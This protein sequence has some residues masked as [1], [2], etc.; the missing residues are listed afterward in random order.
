MQKIWA[1]CLKV[2]EDRKEGF[3]ENLEKD[4]SIRTGS[5]DVIVING[6]WG[7]GDKR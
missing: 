5:N 7:K 6:M 3:Y 4:N 1:L 2:Q